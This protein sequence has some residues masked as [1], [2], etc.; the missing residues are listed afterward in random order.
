MME[1]S[2]GWRA[3]FGQPIRKDA[4][5]PKNIVSLRPIKVAHF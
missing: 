2:R 3:P 5:V 1:R 4:C